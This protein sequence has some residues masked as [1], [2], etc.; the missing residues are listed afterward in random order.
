VTTTPIVAI[1]ARGLTKRF[2]PVIA[3]DGLDLDVPAG[4][5]FGLLG[6][7]GAG[8]TTSIRLL[9]GLARATAGSAEVAG[10]PVGLDRPDLHRRL[11]YLDQDPRFYAWMRG[12]ELLELIGRLTGLDGADLHR[13][14]AENLERAGLAGAAERRIGG[15]SGGM[16]QRL[17]IAQALLNRPEVVFLDEP[18]SS[19]DP[20]G[21]RDVLA[22]IAGLRGETTVVLST[23]VLSDVERV[24]DRV[25]ILD[26]G[27]LVTE[28]P[29]EQLLAEHARPIYRLIPEAG[30]E[31]AVSSL[32]PRL[33]AAAWTTEATVEPGGLIRVVV[34]NPDAAGRAILPLIV[35]SGV[36][37]AEFERA[38]PTLEDVFLELVGPR[39]AD[40]LDGRGFVRSRTEVDD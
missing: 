20:E 21:R 9:T 5:I 19:L 22:L 34:D 39:G 12:R 37:L 13:R 38:R 18:V 29:L 7:N 17:G 16:R 8:K 4:S 6:P 27:R 31:A 28:A 11:G 24:C 1:R 25:A 32:L 40:E 3:L 10:V 36:R 14:V 35:E 33:R 15:Y 2:G 23:H 30:Q 26:R